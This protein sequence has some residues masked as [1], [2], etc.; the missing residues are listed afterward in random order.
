M[1]DHVSRLYNINRNFSTS[2]LLHTAPSEGVFEDH[3]TPISTQD[4]N[5]RE[6]AL[7]WFRESPDLFVDVYYPKTA[8]EVHHYLIRSVEDFDQLVASARPGA[9]IS[10]LRGQQFPL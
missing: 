9:I 2:E 6:I 10:V 7:G 5:F 1:M 4:I 3:V 8:G